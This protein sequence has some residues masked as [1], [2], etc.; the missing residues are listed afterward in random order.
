MENQSLPS[1]TGNRRDDIYLCKYC[2]QLCIHKSN[3]ELL[4]HLPKEILPAEYGGSGGTLN[5]IIG[6]L[7]I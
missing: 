4:Q 1:P 5:E 3:A 7:Y 2:F 6:M